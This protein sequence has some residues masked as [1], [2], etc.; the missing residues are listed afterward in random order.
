MQATETP[1]ETV[2]ELHRTF[3]I[4]YDGGKSRTD[5]EI[6]LND[7]CRNGHEVFSLTAEILE[8]DKRNRWF[9]AGGGCCHE[10][11]LKLQPDLKPFAELHLSDQDGVPMHA[12]SNAFYWF[13]GFNGGLGQQCHGGSGSSGKP[14]E[15]CRRI[16]CEHLRITAGECAAIV[17]QMPRNEQE[18]QAICE[19]MSLP[20][21]WKS[22]A[23]AAITTLEQWTGKKFKSAARKTWE[24]LAPE[25]RQLIAERRASGY[26]SPEQVARRDAEKRAAAKAARIAALH[27]DHVKA[28]GKL[29][30]ELAVELH[31]AEC[32]DAEP[33]AIY[34][35]HT[36]TLSFNWSTTDRLVTREE[37]NAFVARAAMSK[38]PHDIK[39]E[40]NEKPRH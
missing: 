23:E 36:N 28:V 25:V 14:A 22:E 3:T 24:P 12:F 32:F 17:G 18:L 27:A 8:K 35:T 38:L 9:G 16:F 5:I 39:F 30:N 21:R 15:D 26:Y 11:I 33:N 29:E 4:F 6:R 19:D 40:F 31:L 1:V 7:E 13:A 20:A 34:Y 2:A 10:H 37:F